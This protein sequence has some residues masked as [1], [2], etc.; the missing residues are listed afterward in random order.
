[1]TI[2]TYTTEVIHRCE[3]L[4]TEILTLTGSVESILYSTDSLYQSMKDE[5][6]S[7]MAFVNS[8]NDK[9]KLGFTQKEQIHI[10]LSS[11]IPGILVFMLMFF[12]ECKER[13]TKFS[14]FNFLKDNGVIKNTLVKEMK[15]FRID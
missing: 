11:G 6:Y 13:D 3:P 15:D 9:L 8:Y 1:M 2:E 10:A 14:V 4:D 5:Q 7:S 12:R